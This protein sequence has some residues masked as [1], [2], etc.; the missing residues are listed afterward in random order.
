MYLLLRNLD[1]WTVGRFKT[2]VE[3]GIQ[4]LAKEVREGDRTVV[5][6]RFRGGKND[7]T[8]TITAVVGESISSPVKPRRARTRFAKGKA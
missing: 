2:I 4:K 3:D 7:D 1:R 5:P 6:W 8:D